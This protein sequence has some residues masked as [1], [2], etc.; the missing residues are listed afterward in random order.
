MKSTYKIPLLI[1][2]FALSAMLI[3]ACGSAMAAT[4]ESADA[5]SSV[6]AVIP[7][8]GLVVESRLVPSESVDLSFVSS[9]EVA[10]VL[11][12]EGDQVKAGDVLARLGDQEPLKAAIANAEVE[13]YNAQQ[14]LDG[15]YDDLEI[16]R[17]QA[18]Q[19]ISQANRD[20]RDAQ[21]QLDNYT[22][23]ANQDDLTAIEAVTVM[24]DALDQARQDFEPYKDR[25]SNDDTRERLK[26]ELDSAQS[27]YNAAVRRL[28]YEVELAQA[29]A[30]LDKA[31]KDF[32]ALEDGPDADALRAAELRMAAAEAALE[33]AHAA[34]DNLE[35]KTSI[36]GVV[37][38]LDLIVGQRV[39]PGQVVISVADFS[40][41]YAETDDLTEI[42]V[43]EINPGQKVSIS[44]DALPDVPL[45]GT[46]V[47]I[48]QVFE[49][50]RG[51]V[52]YTV[53]ILLDETDPRLRWGMTLAVTFE[54]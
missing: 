53:K 33:S 22:I 3:S 40:I 31:L 41:W 13:L 21:Y 19:A 48:S 47:N 38:N 43:V 34:L 35:L 8:I 23:P 24:K 16:A 44:A 12:A 54:E 42:D 36:S 30:R 51:G 49:E 39:S 20:V 29:Q 15:L 7:N 46:V 1:T 17:A 14:A 25:S 52:T 6:P 11:V 9:G 50:K 28:E 10:E 2:I 27:D 18:L 45:S 5:D 4:P 37:V 32:D 26:D